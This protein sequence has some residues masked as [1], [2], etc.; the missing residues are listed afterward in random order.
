M[1]L[2]LATALTAP[3]VP[4]DEADRVAAEAETS[5]QPT[6]LSDTCL[7]FLSDTCLTFLSDTCLSD[8]F[9]SDTFLTV[10]SDTFLAF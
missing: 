8:T 10:L 3:P 6:F 5:R 4:E 2:F 7:T 1:S 9:W